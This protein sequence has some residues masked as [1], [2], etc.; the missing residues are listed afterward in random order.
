MNQEH[1]YSLTRVCLRRGE[2][3]LPRSLRGI[4]P[5]DSSVTAVDST[6][7]S[8]HDL[9]LQGEKETVFLEF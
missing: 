4:F 8:R 1:R 9:R 3:S 2:L 7:G 6:S 5:E